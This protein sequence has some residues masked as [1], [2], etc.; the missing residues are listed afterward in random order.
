M[1]GEEVHISFTVPVTNVYIYTSL[2]IDSI[3][4]VLAGAG[5]SY[6]FL[7][8][9]NTWFDTIYLAILVS[10]LT[11]C[12]DIG[13]Y[14]AAMILFAYVGA[15][16]AR[17]KS[18][19]HNEKMT[20]FSLHMAVPPVSCI[21]AVLLWKWIL[22]KYNTPISFATEKLSFLSYLKMVFF[23]NDT[24]GIICGIGIILVEEQ[25]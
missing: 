12:K 11:L 4:G 14:F 15:G 1:Q 19:E 3:V 7:R 5:F 6:V 2:Y 18:G 13:K 23:H 17:Y 10:N 21:L 16:I 22:K 20:E 25:A 9:E 8:K 24:T